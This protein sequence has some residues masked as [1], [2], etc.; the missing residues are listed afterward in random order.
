MPKYIANFANF[1]SHSPSSLSYILADRLELVYV[2][3]CALITAIIRNSKYF[4]RGFF[5]GFDNFRDR[6]AGDFSWTQK[7]FRALNEN[8]RK[9]NLSLD[10]RSS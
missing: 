7:G 3:V 6:A 4:S 2:I 9:M 1:N 5:Q 8:F 10:I